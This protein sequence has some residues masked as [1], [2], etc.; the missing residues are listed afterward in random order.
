[1][2]NF[3]KSGEIVKMIE[4]LIHNQSADQT[5]VNETIANTDTDVKKGVGLNVE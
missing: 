5:G 4:S 1:M 3:D 2:M